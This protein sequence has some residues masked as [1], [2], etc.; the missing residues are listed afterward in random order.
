MEASQN[1]VPGDRAAP[2]VRLESKF[3]IVPAPILLQAT[4]VNTAW[5]YGPKYRNATQDPVQLSHVLNYLHLPTVLKDAQEHH[6]H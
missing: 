6:I 3:D 4:K 1:G 2:F 5:D